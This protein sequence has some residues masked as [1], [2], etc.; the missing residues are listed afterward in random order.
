MGFTADIARA[1]LNTTYDQLPREAIETTKNCFL[2]TIG[3]ALV[4]ADE[5]ASRIIVDYV[6]R[7]GGISEA[8]ILGYKSK[9]GAAEA[10][11]ANGV[12]AH[13][14]DFDD[15]IWAYIGHPSAVILPAVL[16]VGEKVKA[17]G[18]D[19]ILAYVVGLETAC[20][21]GELVTP[22][23]S[24][25]G[26][27]TTPT[28]GVFGAAAAAGKLLGL[29]EEQ[30]VSA[31]SIAASE[32]AGLKV[33]FGTMTKPFHAGKAA[34]DGVLAAVLAQSGFTA[35]ADG[36]ERRPANRKIR[37]QWGEPFAIIDPGVVIKKS[38]SCTG[39]HPVVDACITLAEQY[40]IKPAEIESYSCGVTPEVPREVFY[41]IPK[42]GLE[43]K[44][45]MHFC[46]AVALTERNVKLAHFT[47]EYIDKPEI[48]E[49]MKK[50]NYF[51]A[52]ELTKPKGIFSPAGRV[53]IRLKSGKVYAMRVDLAK[54]N[55]GNPLSQAE[56]TQKF[57]DCALMRLPEAKIVA[58]L[59]KIMNLEGL[60][61]ISGL[62]AVTA[63][64][65]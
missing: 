23:L 28:C 62:V 1:I 42:N 57:H 13:A 43:G 4:G 9:A 48:R 8:G 16:A 60:E 12:I 14:L 44:F 33:N 6:K 7:Y 61:D 45:S 31:L 26:W 27:H 54:G 20:R 17:S 11:L 10:A 3:V 24:E 21:I 55:P 49:L 59:D 65:N 35:A 25:I 18:K 37:F 40:D 51:V 53:E 56:L 22:A 34:H 36:L 5:P 64:G 47:P 46:S 63:Q 52:P 2:D 30:M 19:C 41:E 50:C 39:T 58:L 29:T 32:S 38:P 15:N